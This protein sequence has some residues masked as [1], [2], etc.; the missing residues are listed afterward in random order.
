MWRLATSIYRESRRKTCQKQR[1]DFSCHCGW[2]ANYHLE[3]VLLEFWHYSSGRSGGSG[4]ALSTICIPFVTP[5][6]RRICLPYV[7]ATTTQLENIQKALQ[8]FGHKRG[9]KLVDIG[10]GDGRIVHL[11]AQKGYQ[12]HGIELNLWLVLYSRFRAFRLGL[13]STATFSRQDLWKSNFTSYD[14]IVIFGV[15]QMVSQYLKNIY[16]P[17]IFTDETYRKCLDWWNI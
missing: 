1:I 7:P 14:N 17:F 6:L 12:A 5:A 10:S 2:V 16:W 15:E 11:A 9:S 13:R 8:K 3:I 4:L